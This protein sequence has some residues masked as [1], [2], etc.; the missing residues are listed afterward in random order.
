MQPP[1]GQGDPGTDEVYFGAE[2]EELQGLSL[3]FVVASKKHDMFP[4]QMRKINRIE[5]H[6][7][8]GFV[9]RLPASGINAAHLRL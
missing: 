8:F 2:G 1:K 4:I 6:G 7:M 5:C 3:R 9:I